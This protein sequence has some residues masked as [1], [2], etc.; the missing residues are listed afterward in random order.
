MEVPDDVSPA[1]TSVSAGLRA[2]AGRLL[3]RE[4]SISE[5][6][7]ILIVSFFLSAV[8]GA[9]RQVLFNA[10]FGT[11]QEANAYY[12]ASRLPDTLFNLI[13]GGALSGAM[14]PV[15]LSTWRSDGEH[16]GLRLINVVLTTLLATAAC[17]A[18]VCAIFAPEFVTHVLAPGFDAETSL[19][20]IRLTRMMLLEPLIL[21]VGAVSLAVLNSRS[22]FLLPGLSVVSQNITIITGIVLAGIFP[23]V[24]IYGPAIGA[25]SG[26]ALQVL[27]LLPGLIGQHI[28]FRPVWD[29]WNR[30]LDE[31]IR[32][33]I[34]NG[35]SLFVG[36]AGFIL[37]TSFASRAREA[38]ALP[39]IH[40][41]WLLAALPVTL[42]GHAIGQ[43]A[44][45]RLAAYAAAQNWEAMRRTLLRTLAA[46]TLLSLPV[47]LGL[48]VVGRP[49]V[50]VLFEHGRFDAAAGALTYSV[51]V[52]YVVALP[53]YVATE[54]ITRGLIALRDTR[55]PLLT[56][57]LQLA[58]R[59]A[60]IIW[61]LPSIGVVAIPVAFA[62]TASIETVMLGTVLLITLTRRLRQDAPV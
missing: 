55:T 30:R 37:D 61:L 9:I 58:G 35:L 52:P 26:A 2:C 33:M 8:L 15:L 29:P 28:R 44:F 38:A 32:L 60:V 18:G 12:A 39:A 48:V 42:L 11:G 47:A 36:Y 20:T 1:H 10:Q 62:I 17:V 14:I 59:A 19:L 53:A 24:G 51:L 34:P 31:V 40:N 45:P 3:L 7:A 41:A 6:S 43:S 27:V 13:A 25:I 22:Q 56:N 21:A 50:R 49:L 23:G 54:L 4:Y 46:S 16:A 5:G 57:S